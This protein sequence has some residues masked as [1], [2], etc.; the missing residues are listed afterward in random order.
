MTS[1]H[2]HRQDSVRSVAHWESRRGFLCHCCVGAVT[3]GMLAAINRPARSADAVT[4]KATHGTGFCNMGI[5]LVHELALAEADGPS[6]VRQYSDHR[7]HHLRVRRRPDRRVF[8]PVHELL[9]PDRQGRP[10]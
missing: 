9:H 5:F 6:G 8:D 2:N 4:V 10:P 3:A 1:K 7:R